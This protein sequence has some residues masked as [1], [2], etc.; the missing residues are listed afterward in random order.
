MP[1]N[2]DNQAEL[3]SL[4]VCLSTAKAEEA[5]AKEARIEVEQAIEEVI[6]EN[7]TLPN[8][9]QKT[10]KAEGVTVTIKRGYNFKANVGEIELLFQGASLPAPIKSTTTKKLD[11]KGYRWFR[12]NHPNLF[13]QIAMF[14][15]ATP[16]KTS[17]TVK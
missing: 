12:E 15:S 8:E 5:G 17:I 3:A 9:G 16:A 14:V 10:Y 1:L 11:E 13:S 7:D 2:E 6:K 4:C